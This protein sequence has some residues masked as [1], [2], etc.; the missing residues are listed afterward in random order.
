MGRGGSVGSVG[1]VGRGGSVGSV[2]R[3]GSIEYI[4][5]YF[6]RDFILNKSDRLSL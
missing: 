6:C 4:K 1:S 2:G 3:G 5:A